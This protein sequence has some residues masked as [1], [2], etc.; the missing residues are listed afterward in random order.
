MRVEHGGFGGIGVENWL[1]SHNG[2]M[3]EAF[4]SFRDAAYE[5]GVRVPFERFKEKYKI[6]NPGMNLK[7]LYHDNYIENIKPEGYDRI[8]VVIE[9]FLQKH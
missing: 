3:R 1:L 6:F 7:N 4:R 9:S 8:V 2:N 5:N